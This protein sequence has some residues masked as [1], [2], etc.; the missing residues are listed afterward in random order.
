MRPALLSP[1]KSRPRAASE[2]PVAGRAPGQAQWPAVGPP[3]GRPQFPDGSGPRVTSPA[4][5]STASV[6][7]EPGRLPH[8]VPRTISSRRQ[9]YI[10][11]VLLA[12]FALLSAAS[13]ATFVLPRARD[14]AVG[15]PNACG[16]VGAVLAFGIVWALGSVAAFGVPLLAALWTLNRFRGAPTH[17]LLISSAVGALL[18][19][20]ICTLLGLG[21]SIAGRGPAAGACATALALHSALGQIGSWVVAGALFGMTAIAAT[22]FGFH[23]IG[24]LVR[25]VIV[26]PLSYLA[27]GWRASTAAAPPAA[28]KPQTREA[29][30]E[31]QGHGLGVAATNGAAAAGPVAPTHL[32]GR[33]A[34]RRGA[35]DRG[36]FAVPPAVAGARSRSAGRASRRQRRPSRRRCSRAPVKCRPIRCRRSACSACRPSPRT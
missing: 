9:Q 29:G 20:E 15:T 19:F 31:R 36:R 14:A 24:P 35:R 11:A 27:G 6:P 32:V 2:T 3:G 12:A 1:R 22:E 33:D 7:P 23:W 34:G 10:L 21:A 25:T 4:D 13:V 17:G 8:R 30:S 28:E 26:S 16:P 5:T 18:V